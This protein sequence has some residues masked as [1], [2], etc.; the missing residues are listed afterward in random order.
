[1]K[2]LLD[3]EQFCKLGIF[4]LEKRQLGCKA[5]N[6]SRF[7]ETGGDCSLSFD[8]KEVGVLNENKRNHVQIRQKEAVYFM[9]GCIVNIPVQYVVAVGFK[10]N[11]CGLR[12]RLDSSM[13]ESF[14]EGN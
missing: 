12:G 4:C 13:E 14:T 1:M 11:Y 6:L 9:V 3:K 10:E 5:Q 8:T 7:G 2:L